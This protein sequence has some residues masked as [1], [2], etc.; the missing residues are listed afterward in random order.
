M[1]HTD[2]LRHEPADGPSPAAL[3]FALDEMLHACREFGV[4]RIL[5][6]RR[7]A[8]CAD[9]LRSPFVDV[10][11]LGRISDSLDDLFIAIPDDEPVA[12]EA[13]E[14]LCEHVYDE[15][16]YLWA[17]ILAGGREAA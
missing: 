17:C 11:V 1:P 4:Q 2:P 10:D 12:A 9:A 7:L 13:L 8:T 6:A 5:A 16:G 14:A 3:I 15:L